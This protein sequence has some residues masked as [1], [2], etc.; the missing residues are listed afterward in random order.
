MNKGSAPVEYKI[1]L[2]PV[3]LDDPKAGWDF[4][5]WIASAEP[6]TKVAQLVGARGEWRTGDG[7]PAVPV[8]VARAIGQHPMSICAVDPSP[9]FTEMFPDPSQVLRNPASIDMRVGSLDGPIQK[10][11]VRWLDS[12][13]QPPK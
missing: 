6:L 12:T 8:R 7:R 1:G 11:Q 2:K 10:F 13:P 9:Y 5:L 4:I 3:E